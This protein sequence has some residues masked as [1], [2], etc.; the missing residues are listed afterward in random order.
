[1]GKRDTRIDAYIM[2]S[3]EYAWPILDHLRELIHRACPKVEETMKWSFPHFEYKGILCSMAAFKYHCAFGFWRASQLTDPHGVLSLK[4]KTAMGSLGKITRL[5]DLPSNKILIQYIKEAARLNEE[6]IK[7]PVKKKA[8]PASQRLVVPDDLV[9]ALK[10]NK[11]A[12]AAFNGFSFSN[13]KEYVNWITEAKTEVTRKKRLTTAIE[14]MEEGK[15]RHWKYIG[16]HLKN[17]M[18]IADID[19]ISVKLRLT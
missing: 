2:R 1:M 3:A 10:R 17:L 6:A 15:I 9:K 11:L 13:Q 16:S 19:P 5:E 18:V 7:L 14:W 8:K 12:M 4:E